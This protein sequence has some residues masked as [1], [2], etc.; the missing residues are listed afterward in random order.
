MNFDCCAGEQRTSA[1]FPC[2]TEL[3]QFLFSLKT[4]YLELFFLTQVSWNFFILFI[5]SLR[6]F[7][8]KSNSTINWSLSP[9]WLKNLTEKVAL[10]GWNFKVHK[11][12]VFRNSKVP[13]F[14]VI[15]LG[16][17][18]NCDSTDLPKKCRVAFVIGLVRRTAELRTRLLCAR[19]RKSQF[20]AW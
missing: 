8:A 16:W 6:Y 1:G 19:A 17:E 13:F 9:K 14:V 15:I 7:S 4:G 10:L 20:L 5:A 12:T 18:V 2:L 3:A 11:N